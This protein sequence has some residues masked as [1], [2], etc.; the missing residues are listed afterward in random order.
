MQTTTET[1]L[2][3]Q[4]HLTLFAP[5]RFRFRLDVNLREP[6]MRDVASRAELRLRSRPEGFLAAIGVGAAK[7]QVP[8]GIAVAG[9]VVE[10]FRGDSGVLA[11][12]NGQPIVLQTADFVSAPLG[13]AV[14]LPLL[15]DAGKLRPEAREVGGVR[16]R[17]AG[18]SLQNGALVVA[19]TTFDSDEVA[20][21]A[22]VD[23]GCQTV[24]AFDRGSHHPA[25]V[26]RPQSEEPT[27]IHHDGTVLY[28]L[29]LPLS[30]RASRMAE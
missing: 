10:P 16:A 9:V 29:D 5:Q 20:A 12:N 4:V 28:A 11:V 23:A 8:R 27:G 24:V 1:H 18:C 21:T 22:L 26:R 25:F 14:E 3:T 7:R 19:S 15:A 2:G 17:V 13:D 6:G 30:G